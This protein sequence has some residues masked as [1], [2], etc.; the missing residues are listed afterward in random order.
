MTADQ[1]QMTRNAS[2]RRH[3]SHA[4]RTS[5]RWFGRAA[6]ALL[7][8]SVLLVA[9]LR[10]I[11]PPTT[12]FIVQ[13]NWSVR[14]SGEGV[15]ARQTWVRLEAISP[16]MAL[17]VMAAEDQRFP[18]HRGFDFESIGEALAEYRRGGR[19]RGASTISQQVGKNLFLWGGRS[20]LRKGVEAGVTVLL[21]A[22]WPKER[23]L[24]VYLNIARFGPDVYG[25]EAAS[26]HYF[27]KSASSLSAAEAALLAAVLPNP[28]RFRVDTPSD[29]VRNR[30]QWI[31]RQMRQLGG[32][33]YLES[34]R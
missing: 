27:G 6:A 13:H 10:W 25:A 4:L 17:A 7:L 31:L 30:Q 32:P 24:E 15:P 18:D 9:A 2:R 1:E 28:V 12:A 3:D 8:G 29:H 19:V 20:L 34:L 26:Q 16:H 23:I 22:L 14:A 5:L 11:D 33:A 21:E